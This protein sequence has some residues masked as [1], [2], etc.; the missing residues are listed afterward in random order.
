MV[1][2]GVLLLTLG[3]PRWGGREACGGKHAHGARSAEARA[4]DTRGVR[5][6][7]TGGRGH[8]TPMRRA[9]PD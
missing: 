2:L 1:V 6:A 8:H 9:A 7:H 3:E 5:N 4:A